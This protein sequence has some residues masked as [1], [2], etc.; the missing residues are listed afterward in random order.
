M[1]VKLVVKCFKT[2]KARIGGVKLSL[3]KLVTVDSFE[4][5]G[6][7]YDAVAGI[8]D[9]YTKEKGCDYVEVDIESHHSKIYYG[10]SPEY[11]G[12]RMLFPRP[13]RLH[14]IGILRSS[15]PK[16]KRVEGYY[17]IDDSSLEWYRLRGKYYVFESRV[18]APEDILY[19]VVDTE[20]GR[21][22]VRTQRHVI[23]KLSSQTP[24]EPGP[25]SPENG[26]GEDG[27]SSP[28]K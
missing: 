14:R 27:D 16:L 23:A 1:P 28:Y 18:E 24:Q 13:A 7:V 11:Q 4:E 3:L 6:D 12:S 5:S 8:T 20:Y 10:D 26:A 15:N 19:I 2:G 22:W 21:R 17:V 9:A 25:G